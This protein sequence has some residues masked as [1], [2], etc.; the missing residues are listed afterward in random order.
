MKLHLIAACAATLALPSVALAQTTNSPANAPSNAAAGNANAGDQQTSAQNALTAKKLTQDLQSAGFTDVKVVARA[1]VVQAK[2]KD[3]NPV[4]MTLGPHGFTAFEAVDAT[5][6]TARTE[7]GDQRTLTVSK[8]RDLNLYNAAGDML[9]DVEHVISDGHGH[10]SI[11]IGKGGFLGLGE[12]QVAIPLDKIVMR[13]DRLITRQITDE[14]IKA[15][16]EWKSG[17]Q[18]DLDSN[19]TVQIHTVS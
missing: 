4:V 9:G 10:N 13:G 18:T 15:M 17:Q 16:P 6:A 2:S 19:K 14:Q 7:S 11:V 8:L 1:F 5:D 3:G 12:K